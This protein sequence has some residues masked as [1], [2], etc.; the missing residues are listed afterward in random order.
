VDAGATAGAVGGQKAAVPLALYHEG[1]AG[2]A[3]AEP[4]IRNHR[5]E[6]AMAKR[7][8][9]EY[10]AEHELSDGELEQIAGGKSFE[11]RMKDLEAQDRMGNFEV[12]SLMSAFNEAANVKK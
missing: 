7:K 8:T 2:P 11:A 9:T 6:R 3:L 10:P 4:P 1:A 12:Q 5:K